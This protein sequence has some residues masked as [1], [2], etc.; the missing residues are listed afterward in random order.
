[1]YDPSPVLTFEAIGLYFLV[2]EFVK[3]KSG[4]LKKITSFIAKYSYIF[5]LFHSAVIRGV[6]KVFRFD[7][8]V[9][10]AHNMLYGIIAYIVTFV[11]AMMCSIVFKYIIDIIKKLLNDKCIINR[12]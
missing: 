9:N 3:I 12:N 5:Y 10:F 4:A 6:F 7:L 8:N 1:M 11:I 2:L